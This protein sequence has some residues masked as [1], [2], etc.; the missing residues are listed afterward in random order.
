MKLAS[1]YLER[2]DGVEV[3]PIISFIIFFTFFLL[4]VFWAI[5]L[6][7]KYI[8]KMESF[9]LEQDDIQFG[10]SNHIAEKLN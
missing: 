8:K 2:I 1:Y 4:I 3:F 10:H 9:A 7:K 6:D 5:K